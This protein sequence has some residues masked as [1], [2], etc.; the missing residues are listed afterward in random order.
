MQ[1]KSIKTC[2]E[3]QFNSIIKKARKKAELDFENLLKTTM[4]LDDFETFKFFYKENFK[5]ENKIQKQSP[6]YYAERHPHLS[7]N[8]YWN[9][10]YLLGIKQ[11]EKLFDGIYSINLKHKVQIAINKYNNLI[12]K[13]TYNGFLEGQKCKYFS[14]YEHRKHI[15]QEDY[16]NI[17]RWQIDNLISLVES[18]VSIAIERIQKCTLNHKEISSFYTNELNIINNILNLPFKFKNTLIKYISQLSFINYNEVKN[19]DEGQI[20]KSINLILNKR[21]NESVYDIEYFRSKKSKK[22]CFLPDE[23]ILIHLIFKIKYLLQNQL[24]KGISQDKYITIN[25]KHELLNAINE[26]KNEANEIIT[27]HKIDNNSNSKEKSINYLK[28]NLFETYR[29]QYMSF[30]NKEYFVYSPDNEFDNL[31]TYFSINIFFDN[32]LD[33]WVK[34]IKTIVKIYNVLVNSYKLLKEIDKDSDGFDPN[35]TNNHNKLNTRFLIEKL[36]I[37]K[38]N[39]KLMEEAEVDLINYLILPSIPE[40]FYYLNLKD[41]Y[42]NVFYETFKMFQEI[43]DKVDPSKQNIFLQELLKELKL[44]K[45]DDKLEKSLESTNSIYIDSLIDFL[46]VQLDHIRDSTNYNSP[47]TLINTK[48]SIKKGGKSFTYIHY[49]NRISQILDL[50]IFLKKE[51]FI[52]EQTEIKHFRRIFSGEEVEVKIVWRGKISA[53]S[54]FIKYLHNHSKKVEYLKQEHWEVTIDCFVMEDNEP[55]DRNKLRRAKKPA[56]HELIE[57]AVNLI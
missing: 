38:K 2:L 6:T 36:I 34:E 11:D 39:Y 8:L 46:Q 49:K 3:K 19:F 10:T 26:A 5:L 24:K 55:L 12:P 51:E 28:D 1:R 40:E 25:Y 29:H 31:L 47:L 33:Y 30:K 44:E 48:K 9:K 16:D 37:N 14:Q 20:I 35:I 23:D 50:M 32:K 53:L 43:I 22:E 4:L 45:I 56:N 7:F 41:T 13:L 15:D 52:T 57:K 18:N 21:F 42:D 27:K 54:Y 17:R